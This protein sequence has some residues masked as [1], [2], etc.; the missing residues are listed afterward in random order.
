MNKR[1]ARTALSL[2]IVAM[3]FAGLV[4]MFARNVQL[5][6]WLWVASTA[7]GVGL[8]YWI[9]VMNKRAEDAEKVARGEPYGEPD[10]PG[11]SAAAGEDGTP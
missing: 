7:C 1:I 5:A 6:V 11:A 3:Y 8:L 9:R 4:A 2:I 10:E